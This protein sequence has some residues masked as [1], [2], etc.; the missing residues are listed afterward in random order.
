[1][2]YEI[3]YADPPWKESGGGNRGANHHYPL[4]S[5]RDICA[6]PVRAF[7]ADN[8]HLYMWATNNFLPDALVVMGAWGFRY[9]TCITWFKGEFTDKFDGP[10]YKSQTGLGQY[11]RG[12]TEHCLFG[13]R[14]NLPYRKLPDGKRAQ[15]KTG[16]FATRHEHS[17]KP[18]TMRGMIERVSDFPGACKLELFSRR[19]VEGWDT[20][21]DT[22]FPTSEAI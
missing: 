8:A 14:G 3:I 11:F 7:S 4:M 17:R 1:M 10:E 21:T 12:C 6:V 2:T 5:T 13:V 18:E 16:F 19:K 22:I 20:L 9:V 15:G